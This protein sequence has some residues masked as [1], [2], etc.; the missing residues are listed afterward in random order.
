MQFVLTMDA[1][2]ATS[3]V[4]RGIA[5]ASAVFTNYGTTAKSAAYAAFKRKREE[6]GLA[7]DG[8]TLTAE[9]S[10]IACAWLEA[11]VVAMTACYGDETPPDTAQIRLITTRP[12]R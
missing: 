2:D 4:I 10:D 5:A 11:H 7:E 12:G 3:D 9:E 1:P 6:L 8:E